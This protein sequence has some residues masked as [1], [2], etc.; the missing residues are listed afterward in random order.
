MRTDDFENLLREALEHQAAQAP[1]GVRV[2]ARATRRPRRRWWLP[3]GITV[4]AA[5][6]TVALLPT[7]EM[8]PTVEPA[9]TVG[10]T[11][12]AEPQR[13]TWEP[14]WMPPNMVE[15]DRSAATNGSWAA[16]TWAN[17]SLT[18]GQKIV[19]MVNR[20]K[21]GEPTG[22]DGFREKVE[23]SG[24]AGQWHEN[25]SKTNM[26]VWWVGSSRLTLTS[27][28]I[29]PARPVLLRV[30]ESLRYVPE[31]PLKI[32]LSSPELPTTAESKFGITGDSPGKATMY[33]ESILDGEGTVRVEVRPDEPDFSG[34]KVPLRGGDGRWRVTS[35]PRGA[36]PNE[37]L[38][39]DLGG[40]WLTVTYYAYDRTK[41]GQ[42]LAALTRIA[43]SVTAGP[44][45]SAPWLG[46][47]P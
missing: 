9:A 10:V 15:R 26:L 41:S 38:W 35:S 24:Y 29:S 32:P 17:V 21:P 22:P 30:A 45:P 8:R 44:T 2:L 3:V 11:V 6:V 20:L 12:T 18:S 42:H 4:A 33:T 37:V 39:F 25:D 36:E 23:V 19:F 31:Q 1:S 16:S 14:T 7:G 13:L 5:L 27:Y 28:S 47:T 40:R 43:E 46:K 34:A